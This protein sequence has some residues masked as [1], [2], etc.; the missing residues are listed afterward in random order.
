MNHWILARGRE[1]E[2]AL[3]DITPAGARAAALPGAGDLFAP[4][5]PLL[6]AEADGR[7]TEWLGRV[8]RADDQSVAFQ[9]PLAR[10]KD[11]GARLWRAAAALELPRAAAVSA[12]RAV[13]PGVATERDNGGAF[14]AVRTAEPLTE[15]NLTVERLDPAS[16][17]ALLAWL[18]AETQWGLLPFTLIAPD[19]ALAAVRLSGDPLRREDAPAG[20]RVVMPLLVAEDG[21]YQ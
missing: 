10:S 4:P 6:I 12:R 9:R 21:G 13:R 17:A 1:A 11:S 3:P 16:E 20:R 15:L 19:G 7:E 2:H 5:Q 8:T 14:F 18:A